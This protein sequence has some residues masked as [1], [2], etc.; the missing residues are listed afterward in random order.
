MLLRFLQWVDLC[1]KLLKTTRTVRRFSHV[2]LLAGTY[3]SADSISE[4]ATRDFIMF[5][6]NTVKMILR[7]GEK[8][9]PVPVFLDDLLARFDLPVLCSILPALVA[10]CQY[11]PQFHVVGHASKSGLLFTGIPRE[12]EN[13]ER[14]F[15]WLSG[16]DIALSV[17]NSL[18][19]AEAIGA[20]RHRPLVSFFLEFCDSCSGADEA[21]VLAGSVMGEFWR[22]FLQRTGFSPDQVSVTGYPGAYQTMTS[23]SGA[24]VKLRGPTRRVVDAGRA[25]TTIA[26]GLVLFSLPRHLRLPVQLRYPDN[27]SDSDDESDSLGD[28]D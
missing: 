16:T 2:V 21:S 18:A 3:H 12:A 10:E 22:E 4:R 1:R 26:S 15:I 5:G 7:Q 25:Q 28:E 13:V 19:N 24:V 27:R 6:L 20:F 23:G 9:F 14:G 11:V 17:C 8:C